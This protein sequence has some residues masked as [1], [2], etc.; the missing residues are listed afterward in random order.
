MRFMNEYEIDRALEDFTSVDTPN[1]YRAVTTISNLRDY[2]NSHSDGWAY[3]PK[4]CRA[5]SKLIG[6]LQD[7]KR[8]DPTDITDDELKAALKPIKSFYTRHGAQP[9]AYV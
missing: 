9:A 6:H 1:L 2:A 4:P 7:A 5:A 3:W 8:W